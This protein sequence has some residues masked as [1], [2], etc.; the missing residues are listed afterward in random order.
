M[1]KKR[2]STKF[3]DSLKIVATIIFLLSCAFGAYYSVKKFYESINASLTKLN[4]KP[5]ATITFKYKTAQRKFEE[6][7]VWDRLKQNSPVYDGDTIRTA[8]ESEATIYFEDGNIMALGENTMA[9][10]FFHDGKMLTSVDG[11][12]V[13]VNSTDASNGA[14][15]M[16]GNSKLEL[17][18][19]SSVGTNFSPDSG[20]QI[21]VM[22]G[23]AV[24]SNESGEA[25][26]IEE[27]KSLALDENSSV[28]IVPLITVKSPRPNEKILNFT[29]EAQSVDFKWD[30]QN[31]A[32][33]DFLVIEI[34]NDKKFKNVIEKKELKNLNEIKVNLEN[35]ISYWR[36]FPQ[37]AGQEFSAQNKITVFEATPPELVVPKDESSF[38]YKTDT[39]DVRFS[40]RQ[41]G[42]ETA[43]EFEVADNPQM[44][45]P[46]V[47][48]RVTTASSIVSSLGEGTW[49]WRVTPYYTI[50]NAGLAGSSDVHSF[51]ITRRETLDA[52]ELT[53]PAFGEIIN[54]SQKDLLQFSW[55]K[56]PEVSEYEIVI[57]Q[58]PECRDAKIKE[59]V[60]SNF[61]SLK[62]SEQSMRKGTWY[63]QVTQLD[64]HGD[65]SKP[66]QIWRFDTDEI[67][68]EQRLVYPPENFTVNDENVSDLRF[69]WKTNIPG[70]TVL[71]IARDENFL[72]VVLDQ[73]N[74][75]D[76]KNF[77]GANLAG[78]SYFWRIVAK[79]DPQKYAT[80][81]RSFNVIAPLEKPNLLSPASDALLLVRTGTRSV[82]S[83]NE[84]SG[85]DYYLFNFY[86]SENLEEPIYS[87]QVTS[88]NYSFAL[89]NF[90]NGEYAW[91]VRAGAEEKSYVD[92]QVSETS[93]SSIR[94]RQIRNVTLTF[95]ANG[96][97][98]EEKAA[99][100]NP[101]VARWNPNEQNLASSNF[102]ISRNANGISRPVFS[103]RNPPR[104]IRLPPLEPG[105]YYWTVSARTVEGID[106]SARARN[107]I[108]NEKIVVATPPVEVPPKPKVEP[109]PEVKVAEEKPEPP[110]EVKPLGTIKLLGEAAN[111]TVFDAERIRQSR[112]ITFEWTPVPEANEYLFVL[113]NDRGKTL[114]TRTFSQTKFQLNDMADL[115]GGHY[116]WSVQA[117]KNSEDGKLERSGEPS[118]SM[119]D[120]D[121]PEIDEIIIN[122]T[123]ILY[124]F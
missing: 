81:A 61:F 34:S 60:N 83:W 92:A 67:Q 73:T 21:N 72:Q 14:V 62:A 117:L 75:E 29:G 94:I 16:M 93:E 123:G 48:Q 88:N 64:K 85:A 120:I 8:P 53:M 102:T 54:T 91:S 10:V 95:P 50:N 90:P 119:F 9:Q 87:R 22:E 19:G 39:P 23:G 84:V 1:T 89:E 51:E 59:R 113:Q 43:F 82:F 110:Q 101:G 2:K 124:G 109:E 13:V 28:K 97:R 30:V 63:W 4:E 45:N 58:D 44:E 46:A 26:T 78:G 121:M 118:V 66:S 37:N 25:R 31:L 18:A 99:R 96:T 35:D 80:T 6:R 76:T 70:E 106:V 114:I 108:V 104:E 11:G 42:F 79:E 107:F 12:S 74:A 112:A 55:K 116:T 105:T 17:D 38:S 49:F 32:E 56:N 86:S 69:A 98:F 3:R 7:M 115:G 100:E 27:G 52:A 33:D 40:W 65:V 47:K 68:F 71:Q 122:D 77:S 24:F 103:M 57:S 36:I 5:I 15:V 111:N 41:N 20:A